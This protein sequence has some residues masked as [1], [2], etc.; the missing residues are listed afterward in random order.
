MTTGKINQVTIKFPIGGG[1]QPRGGHHPL[2][3]ST[4]TL[5][6]DFFQVEALQ[7]QAPEG[8]SMVH[9]RL[10]Y[11]LSVSQPPGKDL[12]ELLQGSPPTVKTIY[13]PRLTKSLQSDRRISKIAIA[14][15]WSGHRQIIHSSKHCP[16]IEAELRLQDLQLG[17]RNGLL[18]QSTCFRF[19]Q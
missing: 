6:D 12:L 3:F 11:P 18:S 19:P 10:S 15:Y 8:T 1:V 17:S 2:E 16:Q 14:A 5:I 4:I 7:S 9:A 13:Q